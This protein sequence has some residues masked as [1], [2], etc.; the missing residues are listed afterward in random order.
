M[1]QETIRL[2]VVACGT[3]AAG[4]LGATIAGA[5]NSR[6][7][8]ATIEAARVAAEA[9]RAAEHDRW[10]RDR[11]V[12]IYS[13]FLEEVH[14]LRLSVAEVKVGYSKDTGK[15]VQ[16]ARNLSLLHLR[17][18]APRLVFDAAQDVMQS[19]SD[20]T[21]ELIAVK[22][23]SAPDLRTYEAAADDFRE[24][25]TLLELTISR[26]LGNDVIT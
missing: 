9:D 18:L 26:D 5:Y 8:L 11:K 14:E 24:K 21:T 22:E 7:T 13:K 17:V 25:V 20:L 16:Q 19:I 1:D 6:N 10:L 3:I 15:L 23:R 2:L 12:D 4:L